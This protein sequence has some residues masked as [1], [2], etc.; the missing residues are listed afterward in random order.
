M[1]LQLKYNDLKLFYLVELYNIHILELYNH[2][3]NTNVY[4]INKNI[5]DFIRMQ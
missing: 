4:I 2:T 5:F 3:K 1:L